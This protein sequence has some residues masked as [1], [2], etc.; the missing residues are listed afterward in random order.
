MYYTYHL[1]IFLNILMIF[2]NKKCIIIAVLTSYVTI[3][4]PIKIIQKL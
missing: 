1:A 4:V 3:N 2:K